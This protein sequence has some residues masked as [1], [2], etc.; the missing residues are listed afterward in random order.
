MAENTPNL[1][2]IVGLG[3]PGQQ[4]A[5][6]R[7]NVGWEV[8]DV[9]AKRHGLQFRTRQARAEIARGTIAGR[10][11][12]LAKPQ[13]FM[14]LSG[15]SVAAL[16]RFYKLPLTQVLI[17]HDELDLPLGTIRLRERGSAAGHN[18]LTSV[19]QQLGTANVPRLRIGIERP[20]VP[21]D[22]VN[23]VLGH[24]SAS[25]R[26][27][28][29]PALDTAADAVE[30]WLREGITTA[31]N[32][33]NGGQGAGDQASGARDQRRPASGAAPPAQS[34]DP[35]SSSQNPKA[36][37]PNSRPLS[38]L[39]AQI[40]GLQARLGQRPAPDAGGDREDSE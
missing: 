8:L 36:P 5:R 16:V 1:Y 21:G 19:I 25:E 34:T 4:Y 10:P 17:V 22:Q 39:G 35:K 32:R 3:N 23:W 20:P 7:H 37:T 30:T 14:N 13:T 40:A 15:Q 24:F 28:L 29:A 9:L 33:F 26:A 11:V 6:T 38:G 27:E 2:L 12:L 18:G 31:M